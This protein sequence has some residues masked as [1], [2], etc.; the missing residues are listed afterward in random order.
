MEKQLMHFSTGQ[1]IRICADGT[2]S[3]GTTGTISNAPKQVSS[4]SEGWICDYI[5]KI[6]IP[7]GI[8]TF[9]WILFDSPQYDEIGDGHYIEAEIEVSYLEPI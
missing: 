2:F 7:N 5:R 1:R 6:K 9:Y 3:K 4:F 8:K